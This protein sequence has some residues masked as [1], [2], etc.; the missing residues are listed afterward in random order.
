MSEGIPIRLLSELTGVA[1]TTLRAWERRYKLLTP[2]RTA[3]GHRLYS[4]ADVDLVKGVVARLQS[5]MSISEAVRQQRQPGEPSQT[6]ESASQWPTF[7]RRMLHAVEQFDEAKLD[8]S[9]NETLSLYPFGLVSESLII[10]VLKTLGERWQQR[11]NGIAEEHFFSA[12]LRNKLGARLH[13]EAQR[14]HGNMLLVACLPG[15]LHEVG[16]LLFAI[17]AMSRG[18]RLLYLGPNS[19]LTQLAAVA[20]RAGAEAIVLSGTSAVLAEVEAQW[21]ELTKTKLPLLVGGRFSEQY[22]EWIEQHGAVSLGGAQS[23]AIDTLLSVAPPY[24]RAAP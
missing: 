1:A 13:H 18:Y 21:S 7:Q 3:K 9:Y 15:E 23:K 10:P 5:G 4:Q 8:A 14:K 17:E 16:V 2:Q 24:S 22:Q 11:P 20:E 19:P 12:Y 6:S